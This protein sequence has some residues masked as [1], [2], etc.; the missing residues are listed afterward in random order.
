MTVGETDD[1]RAPAV[2]ADPGPKAGELLDGRYR[3]DELI[4][5]GGMARVYRASDVMLGRTVAVKVFRSGTADGAD[6]TRKASETTLLASLSHPSLVTLFDARVDTDE[7]A[8]LVMEYIEGSTLADRIAAGPIASADAAS[9]VGDLGEALHVVHAAGIIHRDIKPSNILLRPPLL[10][11]HSFR[12]T[13]AD[14]GIAHLVDAARVTLPGTVMGTAAYLAPEQVRGAEPTTAADIYALGLVVIEAL[15]GRRAFPQA[16]THEALIAR[17]TSQ[18]EIPGDLGYG[19][20]S[21]LSAMTATDPAQR[22]TALEVAV[23]GSRID[24]GAIDADVTGVAGV[25]LEE[26]GGSVVPPVP[27]LPPIPALPAEAFVSGEVRSGSGMPAADTA[28]ESSPDRTKVL[29]LPVTVTER[30]PVTGESVLE[31]RGRTG[32]VPSD[33]G[34]LDDPAHERSDGAVA[35]SRARRSWG[36]VI[37]IVAGGLAAVAVTAVLIGW[38]ASASAPPASPELPELPQLEEPLGTHLDDLLEAVTP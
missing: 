26:S 34:F 38:G 13:L 21:L 29:P 10:P 33:A 3:I 14:F 30:V 8:Y 31:A 23:A 20:K 11:G 35:P 19:W 9:L 17:L 2:F 28:A 24:A 1:L 4:G 32:S 6:L 37:G 36:L 5:E 25:I 15:T 12:A 18:P 22:P 27:A 7:G 16:A